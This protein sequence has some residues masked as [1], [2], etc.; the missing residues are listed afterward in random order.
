MITHALVIAAVLLE[1]HTYWWSSPAP[2]AGMTDL[3]TPGSLL[4]SAIWLMVASGAI[5]WT[6]ARRGTIDQ[7][8]EQQTDQET[9]Q[10]TAAPS[11]GRPAGLQPDS[12]FF[13]RGC[14]IASNRSSGICV[15]SRS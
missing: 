15:S 2:V 5:V 4:S 6:T 13:S 14:S 12:W 9:D 10:E 1:I 3:R 11:C 7:Q 8:T